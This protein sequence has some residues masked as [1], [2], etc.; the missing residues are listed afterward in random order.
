MINCNEIVD[1]PHN[2]QEEKVCEFISSTTGVTVNPN[3]L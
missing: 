3:T 2:T 1:I